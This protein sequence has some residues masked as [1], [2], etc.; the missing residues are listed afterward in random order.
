MGVADRPGAQVNPHQ[1][2]HRLR[3]MRQGLQQ[4]QHVPGRHHVS[5]R[6]GQQQPM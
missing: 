3:P 6:A 5:E 1:Q 4:V 2:L